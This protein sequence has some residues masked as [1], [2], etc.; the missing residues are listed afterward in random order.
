MK[1]RRFLTLIFLACTSATMQL[2]GVN[3]NELYQG[4]SL[5]A[6]CFSYPLNIHLYPSKYADAGVTVCFHGMG[7]NYTTGGVISQNIDENVIS[8]DFPSIDEY[9]TINQILPAIYVVKKC[10]TSCNL[11]AINLYGFSAGGGTLVNMLAVLNRNDY[12]AELAAIGITLEDKKTI[13]DAIQNGYVIIDCPLKS[14]EEIIEVRAMNHKYDI[15]AQTYANNHLRPIDSI[16]DLKGLSLTVLLNFQVPD[17]AVTNRDDALF[18]SRL[19]SVNSTG[20]TIVITS[21]DAGHVAFHP[22]LWQAY[23]QTKR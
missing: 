16:Y 14:M 3:P 1:N 23:Q 21:H 5:E 15:L 19:N 8:F 11:K 7:G 18:A 12:N 13:L 6:P 22:A 4:L 20:K 2:C 10:I 9:G 17:E